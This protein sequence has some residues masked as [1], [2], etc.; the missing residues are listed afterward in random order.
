M[1]R[2]FFNT[3]KNM[4]SLTAA[5]VV[6]PSDSG[7]E[8][9]LNAAAG[10]AITLPSVADMGEGW[11]CKFRTGLAFASSDWVITATAAVIRGGIYE[12]VN[13]ETDDSSS[14]SATTITFELGA[15]TVG[16]YIELVCDGTYIYVNGGASAAA[17]IEFDA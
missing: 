16:D 6:L 4:H 1:G 9:I 3:R 17:A 13:D 7:K 10:Y 5:Y 14:A 12:R 2:V 11:N 15:E 8:F